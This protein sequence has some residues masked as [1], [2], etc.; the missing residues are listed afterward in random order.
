[1]RTARP[2]LAAA[3]V[4]NSGGLTVCCRCYRSGSSEPPTHQ[5]WLAAGL[6]ASA[7]ALPAPT[8]AS[9]GPCSDGL[10]HGAPSL[11]EGRRL[12]AAVGRAGGSGGSALA[13]TRCCFLSLSAPSHLGCLGCSPWGR[14]SPWYRFTHNVLPTALPPPTLERFCDASRV[15]SNPDF[16]QAGAG[17]AAPGLPGHIL[18]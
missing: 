8:Q 3:A 9:G 14:R 1:M 17:A 13:Q 7:R 4:E 11:P 6:P 16:S 2:R 10:S 15:I 12:L 18:P 5:R